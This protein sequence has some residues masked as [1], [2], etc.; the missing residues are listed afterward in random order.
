MN[1][2]L[3]L[4]FDNV[5]D[6]EE[7]KQNDKL[8]AIS[9]IFGI[10]VNNCQTLYNIGECP[11]IDEMLIAFRGRNK[12]SKYGLKMMCMCD[13]KTN[14]FYNGYIY[15]GKGS[16]GETLT[17]EEKKFLVPSQAVIRLTIPIHGSNRNVTFDNW[18]TSIE[19]VDALKK[20]CLTCVGTL[21]K[22]KR[23]IPRVLAI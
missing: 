9:N 6:R 18:F 10:F 22:N 12:P 5:A 8:A 16:D 4:R 3:C 20:R 1:L 13:A 2:L 15:C 7:R 11:T 23:E 17:N 14:Y 21:K 19:L